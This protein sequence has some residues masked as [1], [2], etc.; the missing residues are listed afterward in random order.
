MT[1]V[2]A[3]LALLSAAACSPPPPEPTPIQRGSALFAPAAA[4]L[5]RIMAA[6][7]KAR[8]ERAFQR[9]IQET[10]GKDESDLV[11]KVESEVLSRY[12]DA[13]SISAS[14][15]AELKAGKFDDGWNHK[16]LN[17]AIGT[18]ADRK[19][20]LPEVCKAAMNKVESGDWNG[21]LELEFAARML[22]GEVQMPHPR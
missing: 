5:G 15:E 11:R 6:E 9:Y 14:M 12:A 19:L 16:R 20:N 2:L 3:V 18:F 1:R 7:L 4:K 22:E 21:G 10:G 17:K 13:F 8:D